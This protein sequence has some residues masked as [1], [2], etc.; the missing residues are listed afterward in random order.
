MK[1]ERA[2]PG[3]HLSVTAGPHLV[4]VALGN[5][6]GSQSHIS[7]PPSSSEVGAASASEIRQILSI[8]LDIVWHR[9]EERGFSPQVVELLLTSSRSA[10]TTA[11]QSTWNNWIRWNM[12]RGHDP[13]QN[14]DCYFTVSQ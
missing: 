9:Y 8:R 11:Y 14:F 2:T 12:E 6:S 10:T 4:S 13:L 1:R 7:I 5:V 3:P